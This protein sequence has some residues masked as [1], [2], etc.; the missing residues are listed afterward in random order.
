[1]LE[2]AKSSFDGHLALVAH[3]AP[4]SQELLGG[5]S[6]SEKIDEFSASDEVGVRAVERGVEEKPLADYEK[7]RG[8]VLRRPASRSESCIRCKNF[9]TG[10]SG[11][12]GRGFE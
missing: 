1:M 12:F 4:P 6:A 10:R 2:G 11:L 8:R 7:H 5:E 9:L 3:P